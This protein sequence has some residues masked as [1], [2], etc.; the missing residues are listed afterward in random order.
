MNVSAKTWDA[1]PI[2]VQIYIDLFELSWSDI[3][4]AGHL[5]LSGRWWPDSVCSQARCTHFARFHFPAPRFSSVD[6]WKLSNP[7]I[8]PVV[9]DWS[10]CLSL[11]SPTL[12]HLSPYLHFGKCPV[13]E[14]PLETK[15]SNRNN[16]KYVLKRVSFGSKDCTKE[17]KLECAYFS[18]LSNV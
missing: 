10:S 3:K 5:S 9:E 17:L 16:L 14:P 2:L 6:P 11:G 4:K 7:T 8:S 12:H 1:N 15:Y 13:S 18:Q